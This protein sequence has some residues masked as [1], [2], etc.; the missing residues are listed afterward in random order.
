MQIIRIKNIAPD[1]LAWCID[2]T[3]F[4]LVSSID[5]SLMNWKQ[6]NAIC[7]WAKFI[8]V[9]FIKMLGHFASTNFIVKISCEKYNFLIGIN[10]VYWRPYR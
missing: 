10:S 8:T 5:M 1:F 7:P 4:L 2:M 3:M 9:L 6:E